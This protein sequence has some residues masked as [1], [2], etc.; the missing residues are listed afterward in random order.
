MPKTAP[1]PQNEKW[2]QA[3]EKLQSKFMRMV[4]IWQEKWETAQKE[5]SSLK[6]KIL[7]LET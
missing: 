6:D 1:P 3:F 2:S 4:E 7:Q 5:N